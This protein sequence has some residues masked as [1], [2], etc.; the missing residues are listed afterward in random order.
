[1][2]C[3]EELLPDYFSFVKGV[4]DSAD[5]SLNISREMLQHDSRLRIIAKNIEKSIK[6]ELEK[7]LKNDR[8]EY[9]KF[10]AEFGA[11]LKYGIYNTFGMNKDLLADLLTYY[12][13]SEK[14]FVTLKEYTERI[15]DGQEFIYYASGSSVTRIDAMPQVEQLKDSGYEILYCTD[16]V[17]EFT[18]K[19]MVQYTPKDGEPLNFKSV[20]DIN[21]EDV[22]ET[23][24]Y[25]E[26]FAYMEESLG[27]AVTK[28]RASARLKTYPAA[29]STQGDLS[30]EMEKVI[31]SMPE[32]VAG[33]SF[34][35]QRILEINPN[36]A[37][38][39]K[40]Q[41]LFD[42]NKD[43]LKT[44]TK[45]LYNTSLLIEGLPVEDPAEF[46]K[47]IAELMV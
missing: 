11:H 25:K 2:E 45:L 32:N 8:E 31:K 30:L 14:K 27:E 10:F 33:N 21:D 12:S 24:E 6:S 34:K 39:A 35:A 44:Y 38:F 29:L 23:D 13:S 46:S 9:D 22:P 42:E 15:K 43:A 20:K 3:C 37:V 36:H 17:D 7:M 26:L 5:L 41:S 40:L 28:V 1:M 16:S 4:V 47:Q 19:A 18:L